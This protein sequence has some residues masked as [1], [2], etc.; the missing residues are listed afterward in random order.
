MNLRPHGPE[1]CA[2]AKLSYI[3]AFHSSYISENMGS[4]QA[5]EKLYIVIRHYF[6][7]VTDP[8][9]WIPSDTVIEA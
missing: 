4:S 7:T 6:T 2:L 3:P 9:T 5:L 1:P 8:I